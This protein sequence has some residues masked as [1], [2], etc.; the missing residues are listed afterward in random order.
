M[1]LTDPQQEE[2]H[3]ATGSE[4]LREFGFN[5]G[6]DNPTHAWLLD[7]R[8]VW[9]RN[10]FYH[11]PPQPHPEDDCQHLD[12]GITPEPEAKVIEKAAH[13]YSVA[14]HEVEDLPF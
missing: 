12:E 8:D 9:V 5:A 4:S 2:E 10:P 11:G 7:P 3:I 1:Y 14:N 6:M 13:A